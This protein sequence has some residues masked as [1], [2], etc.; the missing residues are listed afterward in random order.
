MELESII[1]SAVI[2]FIAA[3]VMVILFKHLGLGSIAGLLVAGINRRSPYPR[4][5]YY[6]PCGRGPELSP[7]WGWCC[8]SSSSASRYGPQGSGPSG[9]RC[10]A[11]GSLQIILTG[12]AVMGYGVSIGRSWRESLV[13]G[14]TMAVSSTAIVM[15]MLQEKGEVASPHGSAG[16][17]ILLMQ[18]LAIVPMLALIPVLAGTGAVSVGMPEWR[19]VLTIAGLFL[20]VWGFGKYL[21]PFVLE[22][23]VG[24]NNREGFLMVVMLSVFLAAWAMHQAGL[25]LAL[26]AFLMGMILSGSRYAMQIEAYTEPYKGILMSLF[27]VAVGMSIDPGAIAARPLLFL[28]SVAAV[29]IHQKSS[30]RASSASSS[31]WARLSRYGYLFSW[32]RE[33]S[34]ASSSSLPP[35]P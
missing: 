22:R 18:D 30:S 16:F 27:F 23:L 21:V 6:D 31:A 14:M 32:P 4:S 2:F 20:L 13:F 29:H 26:G 25:S 19:R 7:S 35:G 9:A 5:L 15:Q 28:E 8:S 17:G 3:S 1:S 10:S 12:A 34:S 24:R 11:L 33:A